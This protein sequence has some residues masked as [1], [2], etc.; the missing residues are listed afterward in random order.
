MLRPN[1]FALLVFTTVSA[2][3][4]PLVTPA[5]TSLYIIGWPATID[6]L[7][8][9]FQLTSPAS[10]VLIEA[11]VNHTG[12]QPDTQFFLMNQIGAGTTTANQLG[13]ISVQLPPSSA[14][15]FIPL[16]SGLNLAAGDYYVVV[17]LPPFT[18][19]GDQSEIG[20]N[21]AP[22]TTGPGAAYLGS[23]ATAA[24]NAPY[25][26]ASPNFSPMSH[27]LTIRVSTVEAS[28][29]TPEPATV[30]FVSAAFTLVALVRRRVA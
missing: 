27:N 5:P 16:F 2:F 30:W 21:D 20:Y 18:I 19:T 4:S 13:A 3:A 12:T 15:Q 14:L 7:A 24:V 17:G 26:P 6:T 11:A 28:A 9:G 23:F 25:L 1:P 8:M 10:N 29:A 22:T